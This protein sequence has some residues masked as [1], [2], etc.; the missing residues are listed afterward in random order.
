M[1]RRVSFDKDYS[2][3]GPA[4]AT[5]EI[6]IL[7]DSFN[8][9]LSQIQTSEEFLRESEE[10]GSGG[11]RRKRWALGLETNQKQNLFFRPLA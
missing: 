1:A 3:R 2:A 6:G 10:R 4:S 9:M 5:G 7:V 8:N 11:S